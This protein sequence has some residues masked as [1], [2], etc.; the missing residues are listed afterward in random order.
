ML[1]YTL[2]HILSQRAVIEREKAATD[3]F[4][5]KPKA[6]WATLSIAHC[7]LWWW[8]GSKGT[9]KSS[10][11]EVGRPQATID[12]T[13]G[14]MAVPLGTDV[15][16]E[17]RIAKVTTPDGTVLEEGPFRILSVN[18]YETHIELSLERP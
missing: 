17:D 6:E 9:D 4:G 16:A 13:G 8:K 15:T 14:E 2:Q 11:K 10:S 7:R 1:S 18:V 3:S 5:G 12:I